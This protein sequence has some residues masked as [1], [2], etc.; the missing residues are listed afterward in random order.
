M[1]IIDLDL[2]SMMKVFGRDKFPKTNY[3]GA[4]GH[5][6]IFDGIKCKVSC[7]FQDALEIHFW[8][9]N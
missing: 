7:H 2:K 5:I 9:L 4:T 6:D 8:E 1:P 3:F